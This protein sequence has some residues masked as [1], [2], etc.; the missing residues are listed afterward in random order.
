[1]KHFVRRADQC[2]I[3]I[4]VLVFLVKCLTSCVHKFCLTIYVF[5]HKIVH[6]LS[7]PVFPQFIPYCYTKSRSLV[8]FLHFESDNTARKE[9]RH[10]Y[11]WLQSIKGFMFYLELISLLQFPT[12]PV[13]VSGFFFPS[14]YPLTTTGRLQHIAFN[15]LRLSFHRQLSR[16]CSCS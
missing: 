3:Y 16:L 14:P 4:C 9:A 2:C 5:L 10:R 13:V 15:L 8:I 11:S 1:M 6:I 12:F 7:G